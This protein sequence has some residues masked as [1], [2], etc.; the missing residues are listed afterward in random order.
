MNVF[1]CG[2]KEAGRGVPAVEG[3]HGANA[4][5]LAPIRTLEKPSRDEAQQESLQRGWRQAERARNLVATPPLGAAVEKSTDVGGG[6]G[7]SPGRVVV[8]DQAVFAPIENKMAGSPE[9]E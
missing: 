6:D 4:R 3:S 7:A 2:V 9:P 1:C 8:R 5:V